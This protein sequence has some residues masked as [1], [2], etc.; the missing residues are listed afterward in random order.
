M[1]P[2]DRTGRF[3][4]PTGCSTAASEATAHSTTGTSGTIYGS[5]PRASIRRAQYRPDDNGG[6]DRALKSPAPNVRYSGF[7]RLR[8]EGAR[9]SCGWR[10]SPRTR[11]RW[12]RPGR[13]G[14]LPKWD[15]KESR[16]IEGLLS[17][18][19]AGPAARRLPRV[20]IRP[21]ADSALAKR[22]VGMPRPRSAPKP[23]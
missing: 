14:F 1:S 6:P 5:L 11:T 4:W 18:D 16:R 3:T 23:P 2:W 10:N 19:Q 7:V 15:R 17:S 12:S 20:A 8:E 21:V 22:M 9:R 13:S